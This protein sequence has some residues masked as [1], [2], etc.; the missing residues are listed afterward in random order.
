MGTYNFV[1]KIDDVTYSND[2]FL[3]RF[4]NQL[5]KNNVV[6]TKSK[7]KTGHANTAGV[8]VGFGGLGVGAGTTDIIAHQWNPFEVKIPSQKYSFF[9]SF[10]G[11]LK[12]S[13]LSHYMKKVKT[14]NLNFKNFEV[15]GELNFKPNLFITILIGMLISIFVGLLNPTAGIFVGVILAVVYYNLIKQFAMKEINYPVG[16][17]EKS[18]EEY[19]KEIDN[20]YKSL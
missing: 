4:R 16:I 7:E 19:Q 13:E 3:E 11:M 6:T 14:K 12:V 5:N 9:G 1:T 10:K 20:Y 18:V 17:L 8:G 15:Y 2:V